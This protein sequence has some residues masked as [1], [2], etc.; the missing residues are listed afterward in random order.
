MTCQILTIILSL[1][2]VVGGSIILVDGA[3]SIAKKTGASDF[4]IGALI[5][6]FG[7]SCPEMVVSFVGAIQGNSD[8]AIGNVIG[9]NIFNTLLILGV[10]AL[11]KPVFFTENNRRIDIPSLLVTTAILLVLNYTCGQIGRLIGAAFILLF[12]GYTTIIIKHSDGQTEGNIKEMS[13]WLSVLAVAGG[14]IALIGGG[15]AF[16]VASEALAKSIGVSDKFIAI[17]ILAFGT[18][19]PE[20]ATCLSAALKGKSQ[21][22]LGDI[23]GSCIFNVLLILGGSSVIHPLSFS[24][25]THIDMATFLVSALVMTL[26]LLKK[27]PKIGKVEGACMIALFI[28]YMVYLIKT[29]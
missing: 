2:F 9:S 25:I 20:F 28:M 8:I 1:A 13:V 4:V 18:S 16:V 3:S 10:S 6:G 5:V 23:I 27:R 29:I 12:I 15:K 21:M 24:N 11:V 22:A 14:I 19:L 26:P 7:T 17:T